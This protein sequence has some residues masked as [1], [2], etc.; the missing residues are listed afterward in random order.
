MGMFKVIKRLWNTGSLIDAAKLFNHE[1]SIMEYGLKSKIAVNAM[2]SILMHVMTSVIKIHLSSV[3]CFLLRA[4][5]W[6]DYITPVVLSALLNRAPLYNYI[7]VHKKYF[8]RLVTHVIDNYTLDNYLIWR[9]NILLLISMYILLILLLIPIN[10]K[11]LL[12]VFLQMM[13]GGILDELEDQGVFALLYSKSVRGIDNIL[14]APVIVKKEPLVIEDD[15]I[16]SCETRNGND[17]VRNGNE[18]EEIPKIRVVKPIESPFVK[19]NQ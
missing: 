4:D 8:E 15:Y 12:V 7:R 14:T 16:S 2:S 18:R 6:I 17:S 10:N 19:K 1:F 3:L 9:R 5:H 13:V 11:M